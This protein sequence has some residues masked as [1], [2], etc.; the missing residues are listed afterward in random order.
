MTTISCLFCFL[1]IF[2]HVYVLG[3]LIP[4]PLFLEDK[5]KRKCSIFGFIYMKKIL[6]GGV[7]A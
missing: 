5:R 6:L 7:F 1:F 2:L 4:P 3:P